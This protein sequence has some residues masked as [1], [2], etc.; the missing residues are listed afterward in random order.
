[1]HD[2]LGL[3]QK[4]EYIDVLYT[5]ALALVLVGVVVIVVVVVV[6]LVVVVY[7]FP[8]NPEILDKVS[9]VQT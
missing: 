3:R 6:V 1:M 4:N 9:S 7:T 2:W 8:R 5:L